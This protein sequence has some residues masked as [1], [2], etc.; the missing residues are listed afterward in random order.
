MTQSLSL[1]AALSAALVSGLIIYATRAFPFLLFSRKEP[2]ALLDFIARYIPPL[3][4]AVLLTDCLKTADLWGPLH[5]LPHFAGIAF[6]VLTYIWKN[7]AMISIFGGT[8]IYM[9]LK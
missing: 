1:Q 8:V 4:M 2:P 6:T 5:G 3:V 9:F 7:N